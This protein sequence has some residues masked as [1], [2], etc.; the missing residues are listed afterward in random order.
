VPTYRARQASWNAAAQRAMTSALA[1]TARSFSFHFLF[2]SLI[3]ARSQ[4]IANL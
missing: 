1:P 4:P 2:R 3:T